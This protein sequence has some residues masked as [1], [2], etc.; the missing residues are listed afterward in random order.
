MGLH[1]NFKT[2]AEAIDYF[3]KR[4][5]HW[6]KSREGKGCQ[7]SVR[8][9]YI[10][11]AEKCVLT[12]HNRLPPDKAGEAIAWLLGNNNDWVPDCDLANPKKWFQECA[13]KADRADSELGMKAVPPQYHPKKYRRD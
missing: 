2:F 9:W 3:L 1:K 6:S 5:E 11:V 12:V 4:R 13:E 8:K 7:E 10:D